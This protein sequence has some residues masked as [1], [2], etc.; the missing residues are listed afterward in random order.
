MREP[1]GLEQQAPVH[2][3]TEYG[4]QRFVAHEIKEERE[5]TAQ[6][7]RVPSQEIDIVFAGVDLSYMKNVKRGRDKA[8]AAVDVLA[9]GGGGNVNCADSRRIRREDR[10]GPG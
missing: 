10:M 7:V 1:R 8:I 2:R 6:S 4:E 9:A 3:R 5:V